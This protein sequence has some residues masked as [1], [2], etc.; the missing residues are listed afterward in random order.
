MAKRFTAA[1]A[2]YICNTFAKTGDQALLEDATNIARRFPEFAL[3]A[4]AGNAEWILR[5]TPTHV[6]ARIVNSIMHGGDEGDEGDEGAVVE[7]KEEK[8]V[9][10]TPAT[11]ATPAKAAVRAV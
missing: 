11:P 4:A 2:Y 9:K 8:P 3:A 10:A 5:A 7:E 1:E 6:T